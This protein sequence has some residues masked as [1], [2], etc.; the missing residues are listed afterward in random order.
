MGFFSTQEDDA[1]EAKSESV[2][3]GFQEDIPNNTKLLCNVAEVTL[4]PGDTY[5]DTPKYNE[6]FLVKHHVVEVGEYKDFIVNHKLHVFDDDAK[7]RDK[8]RETLLVY[9]KFGNGKILDAIKKGKGEEALKNINFIARELCGVGLVSEMNKWE[10]PIKFRDDNNE[11]QPALDDNG[12]PK[13]RTG[14]NVKS[15]FPKSSHIAQEDK[16]IIEKA[17]EQPEDPFEDDIPF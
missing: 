8:A 17:K 1:I 13:M 11:L 12:Q 14:N 10:M 4:E 5:N 7:K 3:G 9:D 2:G 6:H 15:I 16:Q